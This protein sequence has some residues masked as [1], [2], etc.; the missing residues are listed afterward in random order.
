MLP[1]QDTTD[2]STSAG[3]QAG[4][5]KSF[6]PKE[7]ITP[8]PLIIDAAIT[9]KTKTEMTILSMLATNEAIVI[10][11]LVRVEELRVAAL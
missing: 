4:H 3:A 5:Y 6:I 8:Q 10:P 2:G 1:S 7:A 11:S 9:D